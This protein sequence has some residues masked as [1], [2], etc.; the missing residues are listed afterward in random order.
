MTQKKI[1]IVEDEPDIMEILQYNLRREGFEVNTATDGRQG[2]SLIQQIK[3]DLALLDLM[4]PGMEG[5]EIC[6]TLKE[7][8][9]TQTISVIMITAKSEESD[10]IL[11]LGVG[12][13]DYIA[14]PFSPKEVVARIKAVLRR[15]QV[16]ENTSEES[17]IELGPLKIFP[18]QYQVEIKGK[19]ISL[20]LSEFRILQTLTSKPN[21]A[22]TRDQLLHETVGEQVVVVDRNIDVHIRAI[23]KALGEYDKL[24][25]T[26]RGVGYRITDQQ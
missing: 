15:N 26:V 11:G 7:N 10:I 23:R 22:F 5:L 17:F 18:Q 1:V 2:L 24:I 19:S 4:L 12:A 21:R 3:P 9:A 14:K 16:N 20:T 13:D 25:E 8:K 6:K